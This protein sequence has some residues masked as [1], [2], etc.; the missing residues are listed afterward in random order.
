MAELGFRYDFSFAQT[1]L[2]VRQFNKNTSLYNMQEAVLINDR[3]TKYLGTDN[4]TNVGKGGISIIAYLDLNSNGKKDTGRTQSLWSEP[5][6]KR[7]P[8]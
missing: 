4:R 8:Y 2:S 7:W 1:G 5:A 3:K 6:C